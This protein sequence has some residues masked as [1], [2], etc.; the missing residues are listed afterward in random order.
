MKFWDLNLNKNIYLYHG[1][2]CDYDKRIQVTNKNFIGLCNYKDDFNHIQFDVKNKHDL[3][4]NVI[5][6]YQ[7]EEMLMKY[8]KNT[9]IDIINDIHRILINNGLFRL[10]LPD[11][12]CDVLRNRSILGD[13]DEVVFDKTIGGQYDEENNRIIKQG[14]EWYP[15]YDVVKDLLDKT[16][17]EVFDAL[18]YYTDKDNFVCSN[19]DYSLGLVN[20]T[21]DYDQR[22]NDPYRPMSI[23]IDCYKV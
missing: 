9:V 15:T 11:Y 17:F 16:N 5:S 12:N 23:V 1:E 19:I 8:D 14:I 2:I 21:P 20:R 10:S 22:I 6:I 18:H 7:S 13:N 3:P 4:D